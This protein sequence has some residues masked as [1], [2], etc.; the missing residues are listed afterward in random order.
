[1]L[2]LIPNNHVTNSL[3]LS[4]KI[5]KNLDL[6]HKIQVFGKHG[7]TTSKTES[8]HTH[9]INTLSWGLIISIMGWGIL[10]L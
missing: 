5:Q 3:D 1:M 10:M 2:P 8:S 6:L 9:R 4:Y 7:Y